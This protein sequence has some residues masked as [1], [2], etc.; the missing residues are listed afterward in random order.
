MQVNPQKTRQNNV[1]KSRSGPS[2]ASVLLVAI[3]FSAPASAKDDACAGISEKCTTDVTYDKTIGGT[4]YSCYDCKQALCKDGGNGGLS[5]TK[6]SSVCTEKATTLQPTPINDRFRGSDRL[7]PKPRPHPLPGSDQRPSSTHGTK[8]TRESPVRDHRKGRARGRVSS[9]PAPLPEDGDN[10]GDISEIGHDPG[11]LGVMQFDEADA[12]FGRRT[13]VASAPPVVT[14]TTPAPEHKS[15]P[16]LRPGP[17]S[18]G[19]IP[20]PYPNATIDA[21]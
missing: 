8:A 3:M 17:T 15:K 9:P 4:N 2:L 12:L 20:I 21:P 7:A 10:D 1:I 6:T 16:P 14:P 19:P 18:S 13:G 5:G 11:D